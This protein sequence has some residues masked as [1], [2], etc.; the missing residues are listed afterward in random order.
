MNT[1]VRLYAQ[2]AF[3]ASLFDTLVLLIIAGIHLRFN[4]R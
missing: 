2:I 1:Q 4:A 3:A